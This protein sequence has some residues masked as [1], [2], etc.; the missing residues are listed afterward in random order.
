MFTLINCFAGIDPG[1][2]V[3]THQVFNGLLENNFRRVR[4]VENIDFNVAVV[5]SM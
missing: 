5:S 4:K 1:T 2:V 3:I